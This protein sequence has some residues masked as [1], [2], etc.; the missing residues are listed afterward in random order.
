MANIHFSY[1]GL[2]TD[3]AFLKTPAFNLDVPLKT[4]LPANN[5]TFQSHVVEKIRGLMDS[6][7]RPIIIV[8]GGY[9]LS[10][11]TVDVIYADPE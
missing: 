7:S 4:A 3:V 5:P 6:A 9:T 10:K 11:F 2:P 8:D 1:I